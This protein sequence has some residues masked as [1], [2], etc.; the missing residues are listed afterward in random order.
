VEGNIVYHIAGEALFFHQSQED[1]HTWGANSFGIEPGSTT[2]PKQAA[3]KAGLEP[4]FRKALL[5]A[6]PGHQR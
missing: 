2:F 1:W 5:R 4:G 6:D 3:A